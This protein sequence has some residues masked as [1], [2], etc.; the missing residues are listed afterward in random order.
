M[1]RSTST[2][3][4]PVPDEPLIEGGEWPDAAAEVQIGRRPS[5]LTP[6]TGGLLALAIAAVGFVGG[7]LI[8]KGQTG[9]STGGALPGG[10]PTSAGG[11]A[12]LAAAPAGGGTTFGTVANV[13]GRTLYVTDAQGDTIKV[14]TTKGST[15]TRSASSKVADIHPGDSVVI[16]GQQRRSGT[17]KAQSIRA[18]AAGSGGGALI[19]GGPQTSA[20][21][22]S[23]QSSGG[24]GAV[25]QLFGK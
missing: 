17:V 9:S 14:L 7:V 13:T 10:L 19:G 8:E 20:I 12:G 22:G 15:V 21:G 18:S 3:T 1:S 16:Q 6:V 24:A 11:P 25:D 5:R 23:S 2:K 4:E